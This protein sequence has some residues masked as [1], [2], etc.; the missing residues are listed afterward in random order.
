MRW[1]DP[2][3]FG[4]RFYDWF[5]GERLVYR[6]GRTAGIKLLN[7][8]RGDVVLDL[9]CGTGLNFPKLSEAVGPEGMIIGLDSS[10]HMLSV[11]RRRVQR[12]DLPR[13]HLV[14]AD[15]VDF[16]ASV[17]GDV[18][19]SA[20]RE[21]GVDVVFTSYALSVIPSWTEA[22]RSSMSVL[23]PGGQVCVVDMQAPT[24]WA[25]LLSPLAHIACWMGGSDIHARPWTAVE[26]ECVDVRGTR[27]RGG[28]IVARA[29]I[30]SSG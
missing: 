4:A 3:R 20:G 21:P 30:V 29:G 10:P 7:L 14:E 17:I 25:T 6:A 15:A 16:S 12:R 19:R 18:L 2:Y 9:G 1:I 26:Q 11:A 13:I 22:W 8:Q 5:S 28:H 24:G 27:V 23:Q